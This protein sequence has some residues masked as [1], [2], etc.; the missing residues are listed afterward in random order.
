MHLCLSPNGCRKSPRENAISA[1][2]C[3]DECLFSLSVEGFVRVPAA[4]WF[5]SATLLGHFN[6]SSQLCS[7]LDKQA[8]TNHVWNPTDC[9]VDTCTLPPAVGVTC[10]KA[11][12]TFCIVRSQSSLPHSFHSY[13][14]HDVAGGRRMWL[15]LRVLVSCVGG[16]QRGVRSLT[17]DVIFSRSLFGLSSSRSRCTNGLNLALLSLR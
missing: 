11:S 12:S 4:F 9:C 17:T 1:T 14:M 13:M 8:N 6:M 16:D 7:V 15:V 2:C 10:T 5:S 3:L